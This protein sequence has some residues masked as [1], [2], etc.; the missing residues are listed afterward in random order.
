MSQYWRD[1]L[2]ELLTK[3][4]MSLKDFDELF[5]LSGDVLDTKG[6]H[7]DPSFNLYLSLKSD[8]NHIIDKFC[9]EWVT[10]LN[11]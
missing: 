3:L 5:V 11:H 7:V 10:H 6:E 2:V 8:S 1:S 9:E 4:Q